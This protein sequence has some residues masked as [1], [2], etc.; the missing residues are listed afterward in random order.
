[1]N[2]VILFLLIVASIRVSAQADTI[3]ITNDSST[4]SNPEIEALCSELGIPN[5]VEAD[6]D[7]L[8]FVLDWR[9]T[10][11]CYGGSSKECTDCSG[12]TS[13]VYKQVYEKNIPR[14]S[15]DIYSNSMPIRKNALY[16]GDLVFFATSGGDVISH[17]GIYL[18][19]GFF[20]HASSSKGVTISNLRT[21]YYMKTFV[22]GGAW[23]D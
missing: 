5:N 4:T 23:I 6:L 3:A 20:A 21:G 17:V 16:E 12:F 22:S 18:W 19:D 14:V 10:K 2:K 11:Y 8:I 1:M 15:R 13:N 9:G 7:L